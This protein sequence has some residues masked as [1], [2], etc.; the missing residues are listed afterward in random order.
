MGG[1]RNDVRSAD[2]PA[3]PGLDIE[4]ARQHDI[5]ETGDRDAA[6]DCADP[7]AVAC[8]GADRTCKK[9]GECHRPAVREN[10]ESACGRRAV[11]IHVEERCREA[12]PTIGQRAGETANGVTSRGARRA[13]PASPARGQAHR[14]KIYLSAGL[15]AHIGES[16]GPA[17]RGPA[18]K[19]EAAEAVGRDRCR[20]GKTAGSGNGVENG[21]VG[22]ASR[23]V[24]AIAVDRLTTKTAG[25]D[26]GSARHRR[27]AAL[28]SDKRRA[29]EAV[30]ASG[31]TEPTIAECGR[32][33]IADFDH[34]AIACDHASLAAE[35]VAADRA[36][37]ALRVIGQGDIVGGQQTAAAGDQNG[38]APRFTADTGEDF[39]AVDPARATKRKA[40]GSKIAEGSASQPRTTVHRVEHTDKDIAAECRAPRT[41]DS[42]DRSIAAAAA[43][44]DRIYAG[45]TGYEELAVIGIHIDV[46]AGSLARI[47]KARKIAA[48]SPAGATSARRVLVA[49]ACASI[50]ARA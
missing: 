2:Q 41:A 16:P 12:A 1:R 48:S 25:I 20:P 18:A 50:A 31:L 6:A 32:R 8:S 27:T 49:I 13:Q 5:G 15:A 10:V 11:R 3:L 35:P 44:A 9:L 30:A 28:Q 38:P 39:L 17:S 24:A 23:A 29:A 7:R 46:A 19:H 40:E 22:T 36:A 14:G 43:Q 4:I 21:D 33:I 45:R 34:P 42:P 26:I 47:D 37:A